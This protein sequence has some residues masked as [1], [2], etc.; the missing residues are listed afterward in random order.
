MV[1][2]A[3][4]AVANGKVGVKISFSLEKRTYADEC[5]KWALLIGCSDAGYIESVSSSRHRCAD[6]DGRSLGGSRLTVVRFSPAR[7]LTGRYGSMRITRQEAESTLLL[8]L[9]RTFESSSTLSPY[10]ALRAWEDT[11]QDSNLAQHVRFWHR[12]LQMIWQAGSS[13]LLLREELTLAAPSVAAT[14][15]VDAGTA[16]AASGWSVA[17]WMP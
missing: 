4:A 16:G 10:S 13:L 14:S 11:F 6:Y 7:S 8:D 12:L 5:L 1:W 15:T 9:A 3:A 17:E 2:R